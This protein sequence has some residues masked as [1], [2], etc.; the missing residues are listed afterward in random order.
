MKSKLNKMSES[1]A[2]DL[3]AQAA[4]EGKKKPR[5][6]TNA[7]DEAQVRLVL[8]C[9]LS[10]NMYSQ[11]EKL[12]WA[13]QMEPMHHDTFDGYV[14][15]IGTHISTL[16]EEIVE[17]MRHV[18]V[19]HADCIH[20]L[21]LTNDWF[22]QTRGHNAMNGTGTICDWKTSGVIAYK[23]YCKRITKGDTMLAYELSSRSMDARG[24]GEMLVEIVDW[25]DSDALSELIDEIGV[26]GPAKLLGTVLDGDSSTDRF[27]EEL[28]KKKSSAAAQSVA[29]DMREIPCTNH[30]A[31]NGGEMAYTLGHALHLKCSCPVKR[32]ADGV[33]EYVT[34]QREHQGCNT[35]AHPLVKRY[36]RGIGAALRGAKALARKRGTTMAEAAESAL[37]EAVNHLR[38]VHDGVGVFTGKQVT[39]R[40]HRL[41]HSSKVFND[42]GDFNDRMAEYLKEKVIN[43]LDDIL[44]PDIGAV[45]QNASERVGTVALLYRPKGV[46]LRSTHYVAS[47][48]LSICH[49]NMVVLTRMSRL[50]Y[51]DGI[52]DS[53]ITAFG[54]L[55]TRLHSLL[56]LSYSEEQDT[57][58]RLAWEK[59]AKRSEKRRTPEAKRYRKTQRTALQERRA[60]ERQDARATYKGGG[61]G[62]DGDKG[63]AGACHC[64]ASCQRGCPCKAAKQQCTPACHPHNR[65]CTNHGT[66]VTAAA[67]GAGPSSSSE[68]FDDAQVDPPDDDC[69]EDLVGATIAFCWEI[70]DSDDE[71][72]V[73]DDTAKC[74]EWSQGRVKKYIGDEGDCSDESGELLNFVVH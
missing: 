60:G 40:L 12:C 72:A 73:E 14:A 74:L 70:E 63:V 36:Q 48:N 59:R 41:P 20:R 17:L 69:D 35:E 18:V 27:A 68:Y 58:W 66:M 39:C 9:L 8:G 62:G 61:G 23:H 43:R 51:A 55:E 46:D 21:V 15:L 56:G 57:A 33:T 28:R 16:T 49:V 50:L 13:M 31:K 37:E 11:Y 2:A 64:T 5:T 6:Q 65:K 10:G 19:A 32:K 22:W 7:R 4:A 71:E 42:C 45:S 53:R 24:F 38:D 54:T 1:D 67:G 25:M 34:G 29:K 3:I 44:V 52:D 26:A 47:T 30:L